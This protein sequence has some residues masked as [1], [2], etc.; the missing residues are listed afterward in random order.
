VD[1]DPINPLDAP[2]RALAA[3]ELR[4]MLPRDPGK[5]SMP[6]PRGSTLLH[7][8]LSTVVQAEAS[9]QGN[10]WVCEPRFGA[11]EEII[12]ALLGAGADVFHADNSGLTP[13]YVAVAG[14]GCLRCLALLVRE[15]RLRLDAAGLTRLFP[16][17]DAHVPFRALQ[18]LESRTMPLI[19]KLL[20]VGGGGPARLAEETGCAAP[21][22]PAALYGRRG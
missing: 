8:A 22:V 16:G 17:A 7:L 14:S 2:V 10:Y 19:S 13:A 20:S 9:L 4:A 15:G 1:V 5:A 11:Q 12:H 21:A 3:A 6:G 18:Q